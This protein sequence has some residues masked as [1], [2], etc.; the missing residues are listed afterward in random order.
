V[1][2][3][4][5]AARRWLELYHPDRLVAVGGHDSQRV[6]ERRTDSAKTR[7]EDPETSLGPRQRLLSFLRN[8]PQRMLEH[9]EALKAQG[10]AERGRADFVWHMLLQGMATLGNSRGHVGLI[11]NQE[12]YRRVTFDALSGLPADERLVRLETVLRAAKVRMP[13]KK[14]RWLAANFNRIQALGGMHAAQRIALS[15]VGREAKI[16]FFKQFAGVGDKYARDTWMNVSDPD[17]YDSIALD[18]RVKKVSDALGLAFH[19]YASYERYYQELA[20]EAGRQTWEVDRLFYWFNA[21]VL[22]AVNA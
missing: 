10:V 3:I 9:L 13:A 8:P 11:D 18:S 22:A 20:R 12:N 2:A 7:S 19:D 6:P 17:F 21:E 15:Q 4:H 1:R 5:L 14:A 16:A